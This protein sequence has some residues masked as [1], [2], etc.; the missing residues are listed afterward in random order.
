METCR[1]F[2]TMLLDDIDIEVDRVD[3]LSLLRGHLMGQIVYL[4]SG[5]TSPSIELT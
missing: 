2:S 5:I 3:Y 4:D 1:H